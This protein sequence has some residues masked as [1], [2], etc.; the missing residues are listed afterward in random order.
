M[1]Q[2]GRK[3]SPCWIGP[4]LEYASNSDPIQRKLS[5]RRSSGSELGCML[6]YSIAIRRD[7][8][9]LATGLSMAGAI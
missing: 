8:S 1:E 7:P 5:R 2:R 6:E 9:I 3:L 4:S